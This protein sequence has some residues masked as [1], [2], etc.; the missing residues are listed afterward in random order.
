MTTPRRL[1]HPNA[2]VGSTSSIVGAELVVELAK[3]LFGWDISTG[4]GILIAGAV[5]AVVLAIGRD[6]V[7]GLWRRLLDGQAG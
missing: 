7:R 4:Y 6:G 1:R 3:D 5:S 2:V